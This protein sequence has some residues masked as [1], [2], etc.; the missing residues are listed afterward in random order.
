M[1]CPPFSSLRPFERLHAS[2]GKV[3][4]LED[5]APEF[6]LSA[7]RRAHKHK[8]GI[9]CA[10]CGTAR[11]MSEESERKKPWLPSF[12]GRALMGVSGWMKKTAG[13]IETCATPASTVDVAIKFNEDP[14]ASRS[15]RDSRRRPIPPVEGK[16]VGKNPMSLDSGP[17]KDRRSPS[18]VG[19]RGT[20]NRG[21][22]NSED[23]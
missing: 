14:A 12:A 9:L 2:F 13:S 3:K 4:K 20:P 5:R 23:E 1:V 18:P 6:A 7:A 15:S 10:F 8:A 16:P 11:N 19:R 22:Q 21:R 17:P